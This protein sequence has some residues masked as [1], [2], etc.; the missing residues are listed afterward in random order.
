[1]SRKPWQNAKWIKRRSEIL[2]KRNVCESKYCNSNKNL[3]ISHND[4]SSRWTS[5]YM[6]L[7]DD[8]I[9]V[10]CAKCHLAFH[11]G[12]ELCSCG[13]WK[14]IHFPTCLKCKSK[15]MEIIKIE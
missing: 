11:K 12:I 8:E 14:K 9:T 7:R 3:Q 15:K 13:G 2:L 5:S 4:R 6:E 10:K 1:M